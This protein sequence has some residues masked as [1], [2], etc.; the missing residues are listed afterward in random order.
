MLNAAARLLFTVGK[1]DRIRRII[2]DRLHWLPVPRCPR[3]IQFKVCLLTYKVVHGLGPR[4]LRDELHSV[5]LW[6]LSKPGND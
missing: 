2:R 4:Y 1:F 3:R 6:Q 5:A